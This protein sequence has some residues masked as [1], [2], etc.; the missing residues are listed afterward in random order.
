MCVTFFIYST[1]FITGHTLIW[2]ADATVQHLPLLTSFRSQVLEFLQHPFQPLNHWSW[3]FGLGAD[4]LSIYSYYNIGD[5][6]SYLSLLFPASKIV[7]AYQLI[8]I[9]RL[10]C[11][12][13]AFCYFG[14]HFSLS[15]LSIVAGSLVYLFNTFLEY[16]HL[17]QPFF[18]TA[19]ILFPLIIIALEKVFQNGSKWPLLAVFTWMLISNFYFAYMLGIG[20]MVYVVLRYLFYYRK[21]PQFKLLKTLFTLAW[22]TIGSLALSA[23]VLIPE[24]IFTLNSTRS[25][26]AFA[27]GL[28]LY[29]LSY[30]L[31]L[32][33]QL[34][35]GGSNNLLFW[36]ALGFASVVFFAIIYIFIKAKDYPLLATIFG[37]SFIILLIPAGGAFLNGMMSPSNRWTF[38]LCFALAFATAILFENI[39]HLSKTTLKIFAYSTVVYGS[40]VTLIYFIKNN[41][42]LFIP[43]IF[44]LISLS[45]I[46]LI[47]TKSQTTQKARQLMLGTLLLNVILNGVYFAAPFNNSFANK[48]L[49]QGEYANLQKNRYYNLDQNI[50]P[51][52]EFRVSTISKNYDLGGSLNYLALSNSINSPLNSINSFYSL[53]NKN[54]GTFSQDMQNIQYLANIPLGQVD[55]RTVLN[56]FLGVRYLFMMINQPNAK[57]IPA[58][59]HQDQASTL[60]PDPY[61]NQKNDQQTIR[62]KT[63]YAFPL[64]YWQDTVIKPKDYKRLNAT[65]KE[66]LLAQAVLISQDTSAKDLSLF[67]D[68]KTLS[69]N[70]PF[71]IYSNHLKDEQP[72][73]L[74][75]QKIIKQDPD[76][77]YTL[78]LQKPQKYLDSEL[79]LQFNKINYAPFTMSKLIEIQKAAKLNSQ[80]RQPET[81]L[82]FNHR[83]YDMY[84][85][86]SNIFKELTDQS[87]KITVKSSKAQEQIVQRH[88]SSTSFY[89]VVDQ[90]TMNLGYY[91]KLP[92]KLKLDLSKLGTYH[93][94]VK[95]IAEPL[96]KP[97]YQAV[98]KIQQ[99]ALQNIKFS[100]NGVSGSITT[101]KQGILTSSIPYSSGWSARVDGHQVPVLKTN[102]AFVGLKLT[103]GKHKISFSYQIPGLHKGLIISGLTLIIA[104]LWFGIELILKRKK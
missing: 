53:Q 19:F 78:Q 55:D 56:N 6:F 36:S 95:L 14:N 5:I 94:N 25:H 92:K 91:H 63:K 81:N 28:K 73:E 68:Y 87:Y 18:T 43:I 82:D 83:Y 98:K 60:I 40:L 74:N 61:G 42:K 54:I 20:A 85:L 97:Y 100:N 2:S 47:N 41:E 29:P 93:F 48:M 31:L 62:Y 17:A 67:K 38:M 52:N 75:T 45:V 11:A 21:D 23:F 64:I 12:G 51:S 22:A 84:Y 15:T 69:Q 8:V 103:P 86:R 99:H 66:R 96:G 88:P 13:L 71:K 65:Q 104:L 90:G 9:L 102:L 50:K 10:Y 46:Y 16:A 24:I 35:N 39:N 1:Y 101:N 70:V 49:M 37:L 4:T 72:I 34:I 77:E 7:I 80:I 33:S 59:Y 32:P 44:L 79:H 26:S 89:S 3:K 58:G 27:N 76:E 30:Y 57:K